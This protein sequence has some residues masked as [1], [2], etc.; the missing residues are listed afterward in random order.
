MVSR[1]RVDGSPALGGLVSMKTPQQASVTLLALL[2]LCACPANVE[3][4][5]QVPSDTESNGSTGDSIGPTGSGEEEGGSTSADTEVGSETGDAPEECSLGGYGCCSDADADGVPSDADL[6]PEVPNPL[7]LDTDQDGIADKVDLC[8]FVADESGNNTAD[9]DGDGIGNACDLC[10]RPLTEYNINSQSAGIPDYM[11]VR[12]FPLSGDLDGDGVGDACDNCPTVANC[13]D[14]GIGE[15]FTGDVPEIDGVNCQADA[16]SDGVG[17]ACDPDLGGDTSSGFG[18]QDD[19]DGDGLIN[20]LDACPRA[21]LDESLRMACEPGTCPMGQACNADGRCNHIDTDADG[22]GD[23]C[24]TCTAQPNPAQAMEGGVQDD[25]PDGD[26]V[27]SVCEH[28]ATVGCGDR[29]NPARIAYHPVSAASLCC[30]VELV[31]TDGGGVAHSDGCNPPTGDTSGC[32]PLL[33]PHPESPG[34][35][36]PVR[37]AAADCSTAQQEAF[38]CVL[39]PSHVLLSPGV[40]TLPPGCATALG[41]AGISPHENLEQG[42]EE[43]ESPWLRA[44]RRPQLDSDFDGIGD[45]CDSC[46]SAWDPSN[47]PYVDGSGMVW[48]D[49][50]ARCN[51][52]YG[53]CV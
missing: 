41:A 35:F 53:E 10:P 18:S 13:F 43:G 31:A 14:F 45:V 9:S 51:G 49:D 8:P 33:A 44:C 20:I 27:G 36:I 19:F 6:D 52:D 23:I 48:P 24:D 16:D 37:H 32:V 11:M 25:D 47:E 4:V 30:T 28:G 2:L 42:A 17:D 12:Q 21:P 22:V 34:D 26:G 5:G 46:R 7:Q 1:R 39:L 38:E 40:F 3:V 15:P 50:G 29:A